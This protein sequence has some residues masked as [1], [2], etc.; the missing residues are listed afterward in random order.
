MSRLQ[1]GLS[2]LTGQGVTVTP[3]LAITSRATLLKGR[4]ADATRLGHDAMDPER[5]ARVQKF[6]VSQG[7]VPKEVPVNELFTNQFVQ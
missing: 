2:R 1:S 3:W 6:Y 4:V 7:I 5:L